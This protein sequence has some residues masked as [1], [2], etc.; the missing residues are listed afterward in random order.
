M[1]A[2]IVGVIKGNVMRGVI[3]DILAFLVMIWHRHA[4]RAQ[5]RQHTQSSYGY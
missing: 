4:M 3:M 1:A 2:Y 5:V